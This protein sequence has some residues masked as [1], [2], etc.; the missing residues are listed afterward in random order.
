MRQQTT[1]LPN[2]A[3]SWLFSVVSTRWAGA[4]QGRQLCRHA[5]PDCCSA[6]ASEWI[7]PAAAEG[8]RWAGRQG[9]GSAKRRAGLRLNSIRGVTALPCHA[10]CWARRACHDVGRRLVAPA[11][12]QAHHGC[13]WPSRLGQRGNAVPVALLWRRR[14]HT[15]CTSTAAQS[16]PALCVS[17]QS[18]DLRETGPPLSARN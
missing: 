3:A 9:S 1:S 8:V 15:V 18:F 13:R 7:W 10:M 16:Q 4:Q 5:T 2:P 11:D 17:Q 14:L 12:L 6:S